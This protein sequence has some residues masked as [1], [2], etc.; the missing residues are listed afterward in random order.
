MPIAPQLGECDGMGSVIK[1]VL[2]S[3][4]IL[5]QVHTLMTLLKISLGNILYHGYGKYFCLFF[6]IYLLCKTLFNSS[7]PRNDSGLMLQ[8]FPVDMKK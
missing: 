2:E 5:L 8:L 7:L 4:S 6:P 3:N 1:P